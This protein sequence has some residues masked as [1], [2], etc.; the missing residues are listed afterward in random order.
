MCVLSG[1]VP[2]P[3]WNTKLITLRKKNLDKN[4]LIAGF[5]RQK[6]LDRLAYFLFLMPQSNPSA[7]PEVLTTNISEINPSSLSSSKPLFPTL[8]GKIEFA[9]FS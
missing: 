9:I 3:L 2:S 6:I 8:E 7:K 5:L 4:C 1:V